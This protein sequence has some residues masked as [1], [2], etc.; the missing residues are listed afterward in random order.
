VVKSTGRKQ[1]RTSPSRRPA[2]HRIHGSTLHLVCC[3]GGFIK[4]QGSVVFF[5]GSQRRIKSR[6]AWATA[7][8]RELILQIQELF[9]GCS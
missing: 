9:F 1:S 2:L 3:M 6:A 4:K 7:R 5:R 8:E